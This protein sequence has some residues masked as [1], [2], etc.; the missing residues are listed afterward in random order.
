[1]VLWSMLLNIVIWL[2]GFV[3]D[4]GHVLVVRLSSAVVRT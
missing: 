4:G 3:F 2:F 1:M